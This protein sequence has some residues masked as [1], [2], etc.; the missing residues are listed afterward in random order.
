MQRV[1]VAMVSRD[2]LG[3]RRGWRQRGWKPGRRVGAGGR[4]ERS[5]TARFWKESCEA[6]GGEYSGDREKRR[7]NGEVK[8]VGGGGDRIK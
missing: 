4:A 7:R 2:A 5:V 3:L 8:T 1:I 6:R